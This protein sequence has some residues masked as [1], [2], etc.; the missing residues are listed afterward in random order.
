M[1]KGRPLILWFLSWLIKFTQLRPI[2]HDQ[3]HKYNLRN[4]VQR[5]IDAWMTLWKN[6]P[7]YLMKIKRAHYIFLM[8]SSNLSDFLH[9]SIDREVLHRHHFPAH[10]HKQPNQIL[11]KIIQIWIQYYRR[12]TIVIAVIIV[13]PTSNHNSLCSTI[14]KWWE[15]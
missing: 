12:S 9:F 4:N 8:N 3:S 15:I 11:I 14:Q 13:D 5:F 1:K 10:R 2:N 6:W 7:W